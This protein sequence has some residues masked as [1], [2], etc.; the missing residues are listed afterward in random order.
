MKQISIFVIAA[1]MAVSVIGSMPL[2]A[3]GAAD[4]SLPSYPSR[5]PRLEVDLR[6]PRR[7]QPQRFARRWATT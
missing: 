7:R 2:S 3:G 6:G 4:E 1:A 5:I